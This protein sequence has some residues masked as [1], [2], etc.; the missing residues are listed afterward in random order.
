MQGIR[1]V[2]TVHL[3][4]LKVFA[5]GMSRTKER[6]KFL[7]LEDQRAHRFSQEYGQV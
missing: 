7:A 6:A 3:A 2:L 5:E 1:T 4:S